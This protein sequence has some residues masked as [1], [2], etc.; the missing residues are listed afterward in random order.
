MDEEGSESRENARSRE[1]RARAGLA[2]N[3]DTKPEVSRSYDTLSYTV[4][5]TVQKS[6]KIFHM[7]IPNDTLHLFMILAKRPK[8]PGIFCCIAGCFPLKVRYQDKLPYP[9]TAPSSAFRLL[10]N[11]LPVISS[12]M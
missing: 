1:T 11:V 9:A 3:R 5:V 8:R 10:F 12:L 6:L 4:Y 7:E 2:G